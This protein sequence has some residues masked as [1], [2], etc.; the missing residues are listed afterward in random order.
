MIEVLKQ[1][2]QLG[3]ADHQRQCKIPFHLDQAHQQL[4]LSFSY[5]PNHVV[6]AEALPFITEAIPEYFLPYELA[7]IQAVDFLPLE[8]FI[9]VSLSQ[10]DDYLGCW[11]NKQAQQEIIIGAQHSSLGFLKHSVVAGNWEI[12]LSA[13]CLRSAT[14]QVQLKIE[15]SDE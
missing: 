7:D 10:D 2:W 3:L 11:H 1:Q 14:V 6:P 5:A 12:Q 4:K 9:T 8:N 13:H 15:V